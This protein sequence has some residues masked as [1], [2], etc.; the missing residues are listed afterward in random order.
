M[1]T[2]QKYPRT[3]PAMTF[4]VR[5]IC[6]TLARAALA[7]LHAPSVLNTQ[8]WRWHIVDDTA[9]L[10]ADQRRRLHA[11]DSA[12]R[13][14]VLS[15]GTAL[16][17]A[18]VTLA[19][20][21]VDFEVRPFPADDD[22]DRL[23]EVRY[24]GEAQPSAEAQR[25]RRAIP[26]RRSDRRAFAGT[27]VP[28]EALGELRNAAERNGAHLHLAWAHDLTGIAL[29]AGRAALV[30]LADPAYRA[31]LAAWIRP[32]GEGHDGVP[33]DTLAPAGARPVPIRDFNATG[34][35]PGASS[36]ADLADREARYGIIVTDGDGPADWLTAGVALS[37]VLLTATADRLA[38]SAMSDLVENE[39]ARIMLRRTLGNVGYPEIGIRI[40]M[41][42]DGPMPPR[43]PRRPPAEV[44]EVVADPVRGDADPLAGSP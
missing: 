41:P 17:H 39:A 27:A 13:L 6:R 4:Q 2:N 26:L 15:C 44:I 25:M 28:G 29:A 12:G 22:P 19:A 7:A 36:D 5:P 16:H 24:R 37:A 38:T 35:I 20:D 11:M 18:C 1:P 43:A 8:P 30:Q 14:L 23:A 3:G 32:P 34:M 33:V 9:M 40:G 21:G 31:E 10:Y 42:A